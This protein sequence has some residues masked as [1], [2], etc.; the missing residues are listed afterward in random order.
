M[1]TKSAIGIRPYKTGSNRGYESE[2][3]KKKRLENERRSK[4]QVTD[5]EI[6]AAKAAPTQFRGFVGGKQFRTKMGFQGNAF[7]S[8]WGK[9]VFLSMNEGVCVCVCVCVSLSLATALSYISH[10]H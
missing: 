8:L 1:P 7:D 4:G 2:M 9:H 5:E 6:A 3:D 10:H